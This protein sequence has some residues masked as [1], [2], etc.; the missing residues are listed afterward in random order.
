M[1][2]VGAQRERG[3]ARAQHQA[4]PRGADEEPAAQDEQALAP[5]VGVLELLVSARLEHREQ[6]GRETMHGV[7]PRSRIVYRKPV[8]YPQSLT[9]NPRRAQCLHL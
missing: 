1:T 9:S 7:P 8:W 2:L 5:R 3:V 6:V 4:A